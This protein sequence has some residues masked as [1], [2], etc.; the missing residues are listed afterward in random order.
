[1]TNVGTSISIQQAVLQQIASIGSTVQSATMQSSFA[2]DSTGQTT[3]QKTVQ[4]QLD[5]ILSLLNTQGGNG[6]LFS[7]SGLNQPSV[8]TTDPVS[9]THL[10]AHETPE[11]L[12]CR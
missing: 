2:V 10:R 4:S 7:G 12:V 9:Y 1:M 6:Y 3:S 8:D 5:Q 11:H